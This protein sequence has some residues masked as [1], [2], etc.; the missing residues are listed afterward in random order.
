LIFRA[1]H[2][3]DPF[4]AR[5]ARLEGTG[6]VLRLVRHFYSA[7]LHD[8]DGVEWLTVVCQNKL[9]HPQVTAPHDSTHDELLP[10]RLDGPGD[11]YVLPADNSLAGLRIIEDGIVEIDVVL[12]RKIAGVGCCPMLIQGLAYFLISHAT[13]PTHSG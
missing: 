6:E 13:L 7:K 8:A 2:T 9:G 10:I 11:L 12:C 3:D 5:V 1:V 4:L